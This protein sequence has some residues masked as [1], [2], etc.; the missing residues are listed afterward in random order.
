VWAYLSALLAAV[1]ATVVLLVALLLKYLPH[2]YLAKAGLVC[3]MDTSCKAAPPVW[4]FPAFPLLVGGA[5]LGVGVYA[6]ASLCAQLGCSSALRKAV[7][8]VPA[9]AATRLH[10]SPRLEGRVIIVHERSL[11]SYTIGFL[12]PHVVISDGLLETLDVDE[13]QAVLSHEEAHLAGRDNL[14]ILVARTLAHAFVLVPGVRFCYGRLRRALELAADSHARRTTGD[15]LVVASSLQKFALRLGVCGSGSLGLA[16]FADEGHVV[17][18]I[19]GLL[20]E[21]STY[22]CRRWFAGAALVLTLVFG[23]FAGSALAFTDVG[24]AP[25][26]DCGAGHRSSPAVSTAAL[27]IGL[28]VSDHLAH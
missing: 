10:L 18:R 28:A 14:L 13:I 3:H 16:S 24:F 7:A 6:A 11:V 4:A 12:R 17:E 2:D 20:G 22:A 19:H 25:S 23:V 27:G 5:L 9:S 1:S 8:R 26:D 21:E 15:P